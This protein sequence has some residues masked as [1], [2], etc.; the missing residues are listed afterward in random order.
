MHARPEDRVG[1]GGSLPSRAARSGDV[2][3]PDE[4]PGVNFLVRVRDSGGGPHIR[5]QNLKTG[6]IREFTSWQAF[7]AYA[8]SVP[9]AGKLK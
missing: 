2:S 7:S 8:A 4:T 5:V 9:Q 6:E 1:R 3:A